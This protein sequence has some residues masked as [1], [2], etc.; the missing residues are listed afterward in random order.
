M[1]LNKT[2]KKQFSHFGIHSVIV[3]DRGLQFTSYEFYKYTTEW[4][5]RHITSS[6]SQQ[7]AN[8]K[9]ELAVKIIKSMIIKCDKEGTDQFEALM[10]QRKALRQDTGLISV[11]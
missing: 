9:A 3:S 8:G 7:R 2:L 6:P 4:G 11:R 5:I 10:E 1:K